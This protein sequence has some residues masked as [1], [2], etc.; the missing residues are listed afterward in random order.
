MMVISKNLKAKGKNQQRSR[1]ESRILNVEKKNL[2]K[3]KQNSDHGEQKE[4]A[5]NRAKFH[6]FMIIRIQETSFARN[7]AAT[8]NIF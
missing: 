2:E 6:S 5:I 4:Y 3:R 7:V 8:G 1:N